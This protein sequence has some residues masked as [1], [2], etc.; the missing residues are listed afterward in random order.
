[1]DFYSSSFRFYHSSL[2]RRDCWSAAKTNSS[3]AEKCQ[4]LRGAFHF[5]KKHET[6]S[7]TA[8][9]LQTYTCVWGKKTWKIP[10]VLYKSVQP[11]FLILEIF[12]LA[13]LTAPG[14]S[15][16]IGPNVCGELE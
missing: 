15:R 14:V 6:L 10:S 3:F 1:M 8:V 16:H 4:V 12:L 5:K 9:R 2:Y 7:Q 13:V 11:C